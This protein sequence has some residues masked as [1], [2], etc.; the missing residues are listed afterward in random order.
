MSRYLWIGLI[1]LIAT[2]C[3]P[4]SDT[5]NYRIT[6]YG[7][8]GDSTTLSTQ[9]IQL[10]IDAAAKAGGGRVIVPPGVF[11]TGSIFLKDY[12]ELHLMPGAK[13]LGS[14]SASDYP[15]T[16][17]P[18]LSYNRNYGGHENLPGD[19]RIG[20]VMG[21]GVKNVSITGA[22]II[23]GNGGNGE[24][25]VVTVDEDGRWHKPKRP[26]AVFFIASERVTVRDVKVQFSQ[27]WQM[28][29]ENCAYVHLDNLTVQGHANANDDGIDINSCREVTIQNC[30]VDVGDDGLVFKTKGNAVMENVL[31]N[32]CIFS[33][34]TRAIQFGSETEADIR[35]VVISNVLLKPTKIRP[36]YPAP[37]AKAISKLIKRELGAGISINVNDGATIENVL[38]TNV[39]CEGLPSP[40]YLHT[41][42]RQWKYSVGE[43]D[44][45]M[46]AGTLKNITIE[47]F[48]AVGV[49]PYANPTMMGLQEMPLENITLKN[50]SFTFEPDMDLSEYELLAALEDKSSHGNYKLANAGW[51]GYWGEDKR[52]P[53]YGFEF[54][55]IKGLTLDDL[56]FYYPYQDGR[57]PLKYHEVE[58]LLT[59]ELF[60]NR[61]PLSDL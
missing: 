19:L 21:I 17:V 22:G 59:N 44:T 38:I 48:H 50:S 40:I 32:N 31:V 49:K 60:V 35:N 54:R 10:A 4:E 25:F 2:A 41:A 15:Q 16:K 37:G 13:L 24:D 6:D 57:P 55:Y 28:H 42:K 7:A 3:Q 61:N 51:P 1:L 8:I 36:E 39:L 43:V 9:A 26:F 30:R 34:E 47:N 20:L 33:S 56:H 14:V 53:A 29:F 27:M 5:S 52:Y 46:P 12:I 23:D 58:G 45:L 11:L 18:Y